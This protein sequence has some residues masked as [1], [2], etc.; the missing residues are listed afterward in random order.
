MLGEEDILLNIFN[1]TVTAKWITGALDTQYAIE[2][3]D[4]EITVKFQWTV[5][6]L[7]W[8]Q[9]FSFWKKPYKQMPKLF[10]V[11]AGFLKKYKAVRKV[12]MDRI[13][14]SQVQSKKITILGYSQ[15]AALG[16]LLHED[17][18]FRLGEIKP[19]VKTYLFGC[20]RV[21]DLFSNISERFEGVTR[22]VNGDDIVTH[23]PF[24][25][26][27]YRHYGKYLHI[28]KKRRWWRLSVKDHGEYKQALTKE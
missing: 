19:D 28:G 16:L 13:V 4:K 20:P 14:N 27:M 8:L 12:I 9:N 10:F 25:W 17:V 26:M 11:H 1:N 18:M 22:I 7:D 23:V 2:E 15:G 21:F 6:K 3:T 5:S 24:V